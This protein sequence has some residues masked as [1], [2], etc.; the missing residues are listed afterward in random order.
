MK[1]K[2]NFDSI[3][4]NRK[5]DNGTSLILTRETQHKLILNK[6]GSEI[7]KIV[8][9][10]T[11]T[12]DLIEEYSRIYPDVD[13][14]ILEKDIYEILKD[15]ELFGIIEIIEGAN[16]PKDSDGI[17]FSMV[18]D[19]DY[20]KVSDFIVKSMEKSKTQFNIDESYFC[21]LALRTRTMKN[22]E[23]GVY[24]S[25]NGIV[26]AYISISLGNIVSSNVV[27]I[28]HIFI[29]QDLDFNTSFNMFNGMLKHMERYLFEIRTYKKIRIALLIK[30]ENK[31]LIEFFK[32]CGFIEECILKDENI[33]GDLGY[34]TLFI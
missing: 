28:N 9:D 1:Y 4:L 26:T 30:D 19:I 24:C 33:K 14:R 12:L 3:Q 27:T 23:Y 11:D 32:R 13:K 15:L 8:P 16:L 20:K 6:T 2:Y 22:K 18:G 29:D 7:L 31:G 25:N 21:P 34:F 17:T 10:F 5:E